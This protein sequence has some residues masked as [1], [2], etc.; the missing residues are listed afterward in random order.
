MLRDENVWLR[1]RGTLSRMEGH[2]KIPVVHWKEVDKIM[3]SISYYNRLTTIS[4]I[5]CNPSQ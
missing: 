1:H 5:G 2:A 4:K 3:R